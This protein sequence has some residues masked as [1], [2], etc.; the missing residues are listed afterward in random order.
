MNQN[1]AIIYG[2]FIQRLGFSS[3][4]FPQDISIQNLETKASYKSKK[5]NP[6]IF[7]I[8][9]GHYKILNY[10]WTKSQWYGGKVFTEAIFKGID[11]STKTFKKKKE[12]NG[13]LE[14]DLL[15]YEFTVEKNRINYLGTWHFNTGLVSFSDDKI[16]L[17]K[18]FKLKFKTFDFDNA[19]ISL[20]K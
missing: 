8:P 2:S 12:S 13:I 20:P 15:Q 19:L 10:W 4:G 16:Q 7:H 9:A 17:D 14:K 3:G 11:T 5:E 6:F 18:A 1:Q